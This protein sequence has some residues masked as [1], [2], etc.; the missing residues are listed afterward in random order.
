MTSAPAEAVKSTKSAAAENK[1]S[2]RLFPIWEEPFR[3]K[4]FDKTYL[5]LSHPGVFKS[6]KAWV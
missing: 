5:D 2:I 1:K 4:N 6:G 3:T